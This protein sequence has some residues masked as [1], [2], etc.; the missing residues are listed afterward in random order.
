MCSIAR[1]FRGR[2]RR[3]IKRTINGSMEVSVL[4]LTIHILLFVSN[5]HKF[6]LFSRYFS[7]GAI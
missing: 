5:Q 6:A 2:G 3:G 7:P 1:L 4:V